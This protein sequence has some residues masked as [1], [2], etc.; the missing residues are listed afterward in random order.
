MLDA[1]AE[2][3]ELVTR[4]ESTFGQSGMDLQLLLTATSSDDLLK[5]GLSDANERASIFHLITSV[6]VKFARL[7]V[8]RCQLQI[9]QTIN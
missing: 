2:M 6:R 7:K 5:L 9:D 1:T 8:D 4:S 3:R